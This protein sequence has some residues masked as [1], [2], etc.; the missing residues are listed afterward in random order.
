[1]N[2]NGYWREN[3]DA[4]CEISDINTVLLIFLTSLLVVFVKSKST[5]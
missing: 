3:N 5:F 2:V 1:M 4:S